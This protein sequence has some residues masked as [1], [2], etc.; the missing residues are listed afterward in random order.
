[1][2]KPG[3]PTAKPLQ[4]D[5]PDLKRAQ[6]AHDFARHQIKTASYLRKIKISHC[7]VL[8]IFDKR[9]SKC[10]AQLNM[11]ICKI[12]IPLLVFPLFN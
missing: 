10:V 11:F 8:A 9:V 3:Q 2:L 4:D 6:E 7:F 1:M 5:Q 12:S